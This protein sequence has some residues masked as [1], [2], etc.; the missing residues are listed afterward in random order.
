M[1]HTQ[2]AGFETIYQNGRFCLQTDLYLKH[3]SDIDGKADGDATLYGG[4]VMGRLFLT[5]GDYRKYSME[6]GFW[7]ALHVDH[8]FTMYQRGRVHYL[9]CTGAWELATYYGFVNSG[10]FSH[11]V[12]ATEHYGTDHQVGVSLNWYWNPQVKWAFSYVHQTADLTNS[13]GVSRKPN[14]D[15]VGL[16]CRI[17]W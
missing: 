5:K 2:K 13:A 15:I 9:Q 7:G 10:D 16:S 12:N 1:G 4:Y 8:P 11:I 6:N 3:F 14:M 17:H